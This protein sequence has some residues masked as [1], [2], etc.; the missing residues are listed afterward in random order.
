MGKTGRHILII[1]AIAGL[2]TL[3]GFLLFYHVPSPP[4]REMENARTTLS[5][6]R[7][8]RAD[9]YSREMFTESLVY[10]DSAM[11][12]W[13][14]ENKKFIYSRDYNKVSLYAG[15]SADRA[16]QAAENSKNNIANLEN[17][18]KGKIDSLN[19]LIVEIDKIF[20]A[21]PLDAEIRIR[22]SNGILLLKESEIAFK[23]GDYL[24]ANRNITDSEYLLQSSYDNANTNIR[25][26]FTSF[27][28]WKKWTEK[29]INE[30]KKNHSYSIIVDKYSRKCFVYLNGVKKYEYNVE[31]GRN[32]VGDKRVTGD[33]A[34]PEGMYKTVK[35][36]DKNKTKYYKALLLDYPNE[37]DKE[38]FRQEIANGTL[39]P[40]A[41]QGSLIEIHGNGGKGIDWTEG[42]IALTD[43]DMDVVFK[44][45]KIGT[46]V[47]IVG[48]T[49]DIA[50]ILKR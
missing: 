12:N 23:K 17:E 16:E 43:P 38:K 18:L 27:P 25:G 46:P 50:Q 1:S 45:A 47:T 40:S 31:L 9:I 8:D 20:A 36:I 19:N 42:C 37:E 3:I 5:D 48:S 35:K 6:A 30:S 41:R 22:I 39:P 32:W 13:K 49:V 33:Y 7:K 29:T 24:E 4:V 44:I 26:Y 11:T 21:Y 10:Y 34:T 28:L 15:L 2:I 14:R